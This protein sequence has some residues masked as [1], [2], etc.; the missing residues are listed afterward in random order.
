MNQEL[1]D[2]TI[3]A[4]QWLT[5]FVGDARTVATDEPVLKPKDANHRSPDFSNATISR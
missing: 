3:L 1:L 2:R 4:V 5:R